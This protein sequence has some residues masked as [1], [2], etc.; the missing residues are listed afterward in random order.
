MSQI[1]PALPS[2]RQPVPLAPELQ[3]ELDRRPRSA[4]QIERDLAERIERLSANIDELAARLT[5][6]RMAGDAVAKA[7]S[8][9]FTA[10][11]KPRMEIVGA[12]IGALVGIGFLI[13]RARRH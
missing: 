4:D 8:R 12:A 10:D 6:K 11:G 3:A 2:S 5:P 1:D 7:K 9:V 13:W